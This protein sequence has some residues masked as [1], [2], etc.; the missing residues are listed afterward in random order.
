MRANVKFQNKL[1]K[2]TLK[3]FKVIK[4]D[5]TILILRVHFKAMFFFGFSNQIP[6]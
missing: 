1:Q 6:R 2:Y 4:M 3:I 5:M